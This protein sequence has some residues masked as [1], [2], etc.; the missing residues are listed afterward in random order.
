MFVQTLSFTCNDEE[1]LMALF[2]DWG[3]ETASEI[4][5]WQSVVMKD[6]DAP[7]RGPARAVRSTRPSRI[8]GRQRSRCGHPRG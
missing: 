3:S 7:S 1:A 5:Y 8:R 4:G 2:D 6:R